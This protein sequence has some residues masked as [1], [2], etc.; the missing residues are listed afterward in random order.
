MYSCVPHADA[1][2]ARLKARVQAAGG[3]WRDVESLDEASLA[4]MVGL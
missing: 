3:V 1:K 4:A 2:T